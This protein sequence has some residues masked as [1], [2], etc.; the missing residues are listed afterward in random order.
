MYTIVEG[1]PQGLPLFESMILLGRDRTLT[2][3]RSARNRLA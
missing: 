3:L 1:A 2:R